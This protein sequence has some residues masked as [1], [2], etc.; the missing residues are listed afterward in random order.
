MEKIF[1]YKKHFSVVNKKTEILKD[2]EK[3]NER[4][5]FRDETSLFFFFVEKIKQIW[6]DFIEFFSEKAI[7]FCIFCFWLGFFEIFF[8]VNVIF[9]WF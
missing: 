2:V 3:K 4:N 1:D 9:F 6:D 5:S 8:V 7:F